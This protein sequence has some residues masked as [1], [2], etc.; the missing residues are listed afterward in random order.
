MT[1]KLLLSSLLLLW[2][3]TAWAVISA[4]MPKQSA[5]IIGA[6]DIAAWVIA[7]CIVLGLFFLCIWAMRKLSGLAVNSTGKMR[8]VDSLALG[9]REKVILLQVGHKQLILG[10]TQGHIAALHVLEGDD[11]IPQE[12][13]RVSA[14]EHSFAQKLLQAIKADPHA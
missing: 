2:L 1:F 4:D 14:A 10:V 12:D 8:I 11:C 5:R 9:V 7:L 6:G 3:P 13:K